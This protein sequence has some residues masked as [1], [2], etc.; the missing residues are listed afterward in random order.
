MSTTD[1]GTMPVPSTRSSS[2]MPVGSVFVADAPIFVIGCA[3]LVG[4]SPL[5]SWPLTAACAAAPPPR[6]P[7]DAGAAGMD[8][9]SVPHEPHS[10]QRPSHLGET[11]PHSEQVWMGRT[12]LAMLPTLNQPPNTKPPPTLTS[13]AGGGVLEGVCGMAAHGEN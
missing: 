4:V 10:G 3:G 2:P 8:S 11:Y 9:C 1:P 12:F 6:P 7:P 5:A 13:S